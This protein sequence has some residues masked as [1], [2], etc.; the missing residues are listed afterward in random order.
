MAKVT[1]KILGPD[2][3]ILK[4]GWTISTH[5]KKPNTVACPE[6]SSKKAIFQYFNNEYDN[7]SVLESLQKKYYKVVLMDGVEH[8]VEKDFLCEDCSHEW[9]F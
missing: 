1:W 8:G 6:C 2:H 7:P 9:S 3:P 4:E 5:R